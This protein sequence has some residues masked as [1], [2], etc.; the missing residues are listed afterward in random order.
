MPERSSP[1]R[2]APSIPAPGTET[3]RPDLA[4]TALPLPDCRC[5]S[6][7]PQAKLSPSPKC[8]AEELLQQ[9]SSPA[10][11]VLRAQQLQP[12]RRLTEPAPRAKFVFLLRRRP[13]FSSPEAFASSAVPEHRLEPDLVRHPPA[14]AHLG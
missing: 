8:R 14:R 9:P 11:G 1:R 10:A 5:S 12:R 7:T 2:C 4:T 6:G 13:E 3:L